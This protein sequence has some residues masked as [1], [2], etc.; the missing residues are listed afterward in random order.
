MRWDDAVFAD[1]GG[2]DD[3]DDDGDD[4]NDNN[5]AVVNSEGAIERRLR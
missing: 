3:D 5:D 2:S 4:N 1:Y